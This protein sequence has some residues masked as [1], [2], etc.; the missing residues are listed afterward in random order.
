MKRSLLYLLI[1]AAVLVVPIARTDVG[2]LRPVQTV[3]IYRSGQDYIIQTDTGD[4]GRGETAIAALE[5]L[6]Q[7][8]PAVIYL[9][10][11]QFLLVAGDTSESL[12][13]LRTH[14][15]GSVKLCS[16]IGE[17]DLELVS[18]YL[19][20]HGKGPF[21]KQWEQGAQLPVLDCRG[22]QINFL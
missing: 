15:K 5:N 6:K 22:K 9:D 10:T 20:I 1:L 7:T 18:K 21:L 3:A 11:A 2:D 19:K 8:T 17:P 14:L 12:K 4:A 16:F 13:Q